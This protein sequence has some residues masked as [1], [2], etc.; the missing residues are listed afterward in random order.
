M[1][2][3]ADM[4]DCWGKLGDDVD[5]EAILALAGADRGFDRHGPLRVEDPDAAGERAGITFDILAQRL[6]PFDSKAVEA[7]R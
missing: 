4:S 3:L 5:V 1:H 6:V 7:R 2:P